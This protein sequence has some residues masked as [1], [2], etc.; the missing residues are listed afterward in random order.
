M[1]K[2]LKAEYSL[3]FTLKAVIFNNADEVWYPTGSIFETWGTSGRDRNDYKI[4]VTSRGGGRYSGDMPAADA[5]LYSYSMTVE[6]GG[7]ST[8]NDEIVW[9][10][11]VNWNGSAEILHPILLDTVAI[12][13]A[14]LNGASLKASPP[15]PHGIFGF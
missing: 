4:T 11:V 7:T 8:D 1:S 3:G 12:D 9:K 5:N 10:G 6:D 2:E 13:V 14:G 15:L